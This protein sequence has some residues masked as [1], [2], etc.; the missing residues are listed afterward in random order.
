MSFWADQTQ[1]LKITVTFYLQK[2]NFEKNTNKNFEVI[3]A[4]AILR[5]WMFNN[6]TEF[7]VPPVEA[8]G[9][10]QEAVTT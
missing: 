7:K 6:W 4:R 2:D 5:Y 8:E 3:D 10:T 1:C 9:D